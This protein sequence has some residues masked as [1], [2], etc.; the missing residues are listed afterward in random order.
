MG[1][2]VGGADAA[3]RQ[4]CVCSLRGTKQTIKESA[5]RGKESAALKALKYLVHNRIHIFL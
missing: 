4:K 5:C 3:A 2:E 1:S